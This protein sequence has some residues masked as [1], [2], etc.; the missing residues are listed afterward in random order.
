[1][2]TC[3]YGPGKVSPAFV[4]YPNTGEHMKGQGGIFRPTWKDKQGRKRTIKTWW[5]RYSINGEQFRENSHTTVRAHALAL[6]LELEEYLRPL[7]QFYYLTGW[8]R[9]EALGLQWD[10]ID[11]ESQEIRLAG[12]DTKS[13]KPKS[14]PFALAPEIK[15]LLAAQWQQRNGEYIFH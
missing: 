15:N 10:A 8:R 13:T 14:F 7:V 1:M 4:L 3:S 11:W 2:A 12:T 5:L 9:S 6:L